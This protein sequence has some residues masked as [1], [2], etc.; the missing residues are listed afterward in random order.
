M[1]RGSRSRNAESGPGRRPSSC[2]L[3]QK[4]RGDTT[5]NEKQ[6]KGRRSA[7][8]SYVYASAPLGIGAGIHGGPPG[9]DYIEARAAMLA[10]AQVPGGGHEKQRSPGWER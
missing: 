3:K 6:Q 1:L 5:T 2:G 8:S 4:Q 9:T 7:S 10:V